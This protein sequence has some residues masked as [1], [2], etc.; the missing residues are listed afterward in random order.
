MNRLTTYRPV[1]R[2]ALPENG[3][4]GPLLGHLRLSASS[5]P[6]KDGHF[7]ASTAASITAWRISVTTVSHKL[8]YA[9]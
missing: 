2:A 1:F 3:L 9:S 6:S 8:L 7:H 5:R 4:S